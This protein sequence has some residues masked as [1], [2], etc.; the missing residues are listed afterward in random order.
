MI[1]QDLKQ[2][3]IHPYGASGVDVMFFSFSVVLD[4]FFSVVLDTFVL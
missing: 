3:H 2:H 1:L 4:T